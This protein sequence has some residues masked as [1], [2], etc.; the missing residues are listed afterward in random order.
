MN[1]LQALVAR[2]GDDVQDLALEGDRRYSHPISLDRR[3]QAQMRV[4]L[5]R[6]M[7]A[8][9]PLPKNQRRSSKTVTNKIL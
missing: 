8:K 6:E 4:F 7:Q 5:S 9:E 2:T 3:R 1:G